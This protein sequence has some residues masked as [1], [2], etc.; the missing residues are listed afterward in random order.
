M[1]LTITLSLIGIGAGWMVWRRWSHRRRPTALVALKNLPGN[2]L[3]MDAFM[4][5]N[6]CLREGQFVEASTAFRQAGAL[7]PNLPYVVARLDEVERQQ[8]GGA[9]LTHALTRYPRALGASVPQ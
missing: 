2:P 3:A 8:A 5:G 9:R 7:D 6:S 1:V 4:R